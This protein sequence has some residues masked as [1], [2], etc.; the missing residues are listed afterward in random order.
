MPGTIQTPLPAAAARLRRRRPLHA[1]LAGLSLLALG[2]CVQG[3]GA[4]GGGG[5]DMDLRSLGDGF[6]TSE[7][8]RAAT[9]PRPQ[10][11]ARGIISYPDYQVAVAGRGDT[12]RSVAARVGVG[13]EDLARY[14]AVSPDAPLNPGEVLALPGRVAEPRT[15][16]P[17]DITAIASGA[18]DRAGT[19]ASAAPAAAAAPARAEPVRHRVV[20]GETAYTIA[21]AYNVSVRSLADWNGLTGEMTVREGQYLLIPVTVAGAAPPANATSAPGQGSAT[22]APPSASQPLPEER[23]ATANTPV[24]TPPAPD[25]GGRTSASASAK[26]VMPVSGSIIRG[27]APKKNDGIDIAASAGTP[28]KAADAGTVAAIT[29][30]TDQVPILVIRHPGNLLTV[31]ANID[32]ITVAKGATV[33]RGQPI[34][35]VRAGSPAFMHFEVRNGYDSVDPMRYL[36]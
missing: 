10:P 2:G 13:A 3:G 6:S 15:G 18:I 32:G 9:A 5:F 17:I 34:A 22:P 30:D 28:V 27:Y 33:A 36:E 8:A 21:R 7:A 19:P 31:Y 1:A 20:R 26:F 35:K 11:D 14:N 12:V 24:R 29:K 23:T 16:G 25:L 4:G